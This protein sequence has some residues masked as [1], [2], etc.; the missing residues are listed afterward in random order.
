MTLII[1][2]GVLGALAGWAQMWI[3]N[4]GDKRRAAKALTRE[5]NAQVNGREGGAQKKSGAGSFESG[6]ISDK[7]EGDE[8]LT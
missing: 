8:L 5:E 4:R 1:A 6:P 3:N 2:G 7:L